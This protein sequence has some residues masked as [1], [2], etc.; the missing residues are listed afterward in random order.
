MCEVCNRGLVLNIARTACTAYVPYVYIPATCVCKNGIPASTN[1]CPKNGAAVCVRCNTG[2][3]LNA[4]AASCEQAAPVLTCRD[5]KWPAFPYLRD[6][7]AAPQWSSNVLFMDFLHANGLTFGI[8]PNE[9]AYKAL[10][11]QLD[12]KKRPNCK[13]VKKPTCE[14]CSI[15]CKPSDKK[16]N[17]KKKK[18]KPL[19][20]E[21]VTAGKSTIWKCSPNKGAKKIEESPLGFTVSLGFGL[22]LQIDKGGKDIYQKDCNENKPTK[23]VRGKLLATVKASSANIHATPSYSLQ[24]EGSDFTPIPIGTMVNNVLGTMAQVASLPDSVVKVVETMYSPMLSVLSILRIENLEF[25]LGYDADNSVGPQPRTFNLDFAGTILFS[26]LR[27]SKANPL[28]VIVDFMSKLTAAARPRLSL[29]STVTKT[30]APP[31]SETNVELSFGTD[32]FCFDDFSARGSGKD[33]DCGRSDSC[34]AT[35]T[36][37][38][39]CSARLDDR[40]GGGLS[41][42]LEAKLSPPIVMK[43]G[44]KTGVKLRVAD[45]QFLHFFGKVDF[46]QG[47]TASV[48]ANLRMYGTW[49]RAFG[50]SKLHMA[51]AILSF[52]ITLPI[53]PASLL[54]NNLMIGATIHMGHTDIKKCP[55]ELGAYVGYDVNDP[56]KAFA[57]MY[58]TRAP[59]LKQLAHTFLPSTVA[60]TLLLIPGLYALKDVQLGPYNALRGAKC[61]LADITTIKSGCPGMTNTACYQLFQNCYFVAWAAPL[62]LAQVQQKLAG[63]KGPAAIMN[64]LPAGSYFG[65]SGSLAVKGIG[66]VAAAFETGLVIPYVGTTRFKLQVGVRLFDFFLGEAYFS[67]DLGLDPKQTQELQKVTSTNKGYCLDQ[68][69]TCQPAKGKRQ[70]PHCEDVKGKRKWKCKAVPPSKA[71]EQANGL[72]KTLN[73]PV[74]SIGGK[75]RLDM[76]KLKTQL[77]RAVAAL[78]DVSGLTSKLRSLLSSVKTICKKL[79][80]PSKICNFIDSVASGFITTIITRILQ[81][82]QTALNGLTTLINKIVDSLPSTSVALQLDCKTQVLTSGVEVALKFKIE[83]QKPTLSFTLKLGQLQPFKGVK[84]T[85]GGLIVAAVDGLKDQLKQLVLDIF[86]GDPKAVV[87]KA[88]RNAKNTLIA[89]GRKIISAIMDP[90]LDVAKK[91]ISFV[92]CLFGG[93]SPPPPPPPPP[94]QCYKKHTYGFTTCTTCE[95]ADSSTQLQRRHHVIASDTVGYEKVAT[96]TECSNGKEVLQ[97][98]EV[99]SLNQCARMCKDA[100]YFIYGTNEYSQFGKIAAKSRWNRCSVAY[101]GAMSATGLSGCQ[102]R[103]ELVGSSAGTQCSRTVHYGY[104]L[105]ATKTSG[106]SQCYG[107]CLQI[108]MLVYDAWVESTIYEAVR[109]PNFGDARNWW[110]DNQIATMSVGSVDECEGLCTSD[111]DCAGYTYDA[112]RPKAMCWLARQLPQHLSVPWK[113]KSMNSNPKRSTAGGLSPVKVG[114]QAYWDCR[115]KHW[116]KRRSYTTIDPASCGTDG[117][118][119]YRRMSKDDGT[120]TGRNP[121]GI[122]IDDKFVSYRFSDGQLDTATVREWTSGACCHRQSGV[123]YKKTASFVE[124]SG[125]ETYEGDLSSIGLCAA[126]CA[127]KSHYFIY[128]TTAGGVGGQYCPTHKGCHCR[129][130]TIGKNCKHISHPGYHL[131]EKDTSIGNDLCKFSP[132][133]AQISAGSTQHASTATSNVW[134]DATYSLTPGAEKGKN[135]PSVGKPSAKLV[136][137]YVECVGAAY[138]PPDYKRTANDCAIA[139]SGTGKSYYFEYGT[140][141]GGNPRC[142]SNGCRCE[143]HFG[144]NCRRK[145]HRGYHLYRVQLSPTDVKYEPTRCTEVPAH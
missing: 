145:S 87:A 27:M 133:S 129:C 50:L 98:P 55:H 63:F 112:E 20:R 42:F 141:E 61:N 33:T 73:N 76:D 2:Y 95:D 37:N 7:T 31:K 48:N 24:L 32:P 138:V 77:K 101:G 22:C 78:L 81:V 119:F 93:C 134:C 47:P 3:E 144:F 114:S 66:V 8:E 9:D 41:L 6:S 16:C 70:Y 130:E 30:L 34:V 39:R 69:P 43:V 94:R 92:K 90:V 97:G 79:G 35:N 11:N 74:F 111:V 17:D 110:V 99:H 72:R 120:V 100:Q 44:F 65:A 122:I 53:T 54:P 104:H 56:F 19:Y 109:I 1:A 139:C 40:K 67:Y 51:D 13:G 83:M 59:T 14:T 115:Q 125:S 58:G 132:G 10:V 117:S 28:K 5:P 75:L 49:Q 57:L 18:C 82:V 118:C 60:N 131:Y 45:N 25:T 126:R 36:C 102:C 121:H 85:P 29:I 143:C 107:L 113:C 128:G 123:T 80:V 96:Y 89:E 12:P 106:A 137:R 64:A 52:G 124:C 46:S 62:G 15:Q 4:V 135:Y 140:N 142:R 91:L 21:C 127:S 26:S 23:H 68:P 105:Y 108:S 38:C 88:L 116:I 86:G 71:V 136:A 84:F 103:C